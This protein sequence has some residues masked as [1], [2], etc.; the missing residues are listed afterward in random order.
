MTFPGT[1]IP[2]STVFV[3]SF[4][5]MWVSS[6]AARRLAV[7]PWSSQQHPTALSCS[8]ANPRVSSS[9]PRVTAEKAMAGVFCWL[10]VF[11]HRPGLNVSLIGH[12]PI[13]MIKNW[14]W[15]DVWNLPPATSTNTTNQWESTKK[16]KVGY[17][18]V[19]LHRLGPRHRQN[20]DS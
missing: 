12:H 19:T 16:K 6:S 15:K 1:I 13:S 11:H 10:M 14:N 9:N 4:G 17:S 5:K 2:D 8:T 7:S 3:N 18:C 20:C